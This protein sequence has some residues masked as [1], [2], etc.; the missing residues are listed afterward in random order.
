MRCFARSFDASCW[1]SAL[2][3]RFQSALVMLLLQEVNEFET[4]EFEQCIGPSMRQPSVESR[5][6]VKDKVCPF[7]WMP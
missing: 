7:I 3:R 6:V 5:H 2:P 4:P 1:S